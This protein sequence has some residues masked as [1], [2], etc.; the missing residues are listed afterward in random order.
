MLVTA[1]ETNLM[2]I[3]DMKERL[4]VLTFLNAARIYNLKLLMIWKSANPQSLICVPVPVI[5]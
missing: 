3:K 2:A 1:N 4:A 5:Y